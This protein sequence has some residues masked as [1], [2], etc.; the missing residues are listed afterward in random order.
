MKVIVQ[1]LNILLIS[2]ILY[3]VYSQTIEPYC[4]NE[5]DKDDKCQEQERQQIY[6]NEENT[7]LVEEKIKDMKQLFKTIGINIKDNTQKHEENVKALKKVEK[8][9]NGEE[10]DNS[11]ACKKHPEAC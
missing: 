3:N 7:S 4:N 6:K 11:E 5:L 8:I 9:G 2:L 1:I 10:I